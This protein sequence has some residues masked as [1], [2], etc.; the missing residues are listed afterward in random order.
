MC[1]RTQFDLDFPHLMLR[2]RAARAA[3]GKTRWADR[4]AGRDRPQRQAG[5]L[6][7]AARQLGD[8]AGNKL[9]RPADGEGRRHRPPRRAAEIPRPHLRAARHGAA[10]AEP[11]ATAP[12][13][14]RKAVLYATCF[15][16]YNNPAHRRGRAGGAGKQRRRDRGRLSRLL[17][18]AA[19]RAG[20]S[21]A[22]RRQ[23]AA[24]SRPR[25]RPISTAAMTWSR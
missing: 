12:A 10:R 8:R 1:R 23:R 7:G 9:T 19:A 24:R 17:R 20:R 15:V 4:A 25:S 11:D 2:Y 16:N 22:R 14:G 21:G 5:A 13:F 3:K 18:H 6:A